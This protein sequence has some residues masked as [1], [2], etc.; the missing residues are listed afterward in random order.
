MRLLERS[1]IIS[2]GM[3]YLETSYTRGV[4]RSNGDHTPSCQGRGQNISRKKD[5]CTA[6]NVQTSLRWNMHLIS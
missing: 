4:C 1:Q 2:S 6:T 3:L 5:K